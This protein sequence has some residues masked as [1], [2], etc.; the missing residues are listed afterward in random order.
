MMEL[1]ELKWISVSVF[2]SRAHVEVR[3]RTEIPELFDEGEY[4]KIIAYRAGI[5]EEINVLRG[6]KLFSAGDT[7]VE[8]DVLIGGV[9]E[10]TFA[11]TRFV[12]ASGSVTAR[13]WYELTAILPLEYTEKVY[14][15]ETHDRFSLVIG[16]KRINFCRNSGIL[17]VKCDNIISEHKLGIGG[18]FTLPVSVVR[19][20][21]EEYELQTSGYSE[22]QARRLLEAILNDE[23]LQSIGADGEVVES[24]FT[25]SVLNGY[26][27]GT[28][29]AECRQNIAAEEPLTADE[30][31]RAKAAGDEPVP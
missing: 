14:T 5:I 27:V 8:G 12:H 21:S 13:T 30:I 15:G 28:L 7:A 17:S 24:E 1:P 20:R 25:I 18:L 6:N 3:E 2:G 31:S 16:D 26:A 9:V 10:S 23:L 19:E 29:R 22:A 11:D 4:Y